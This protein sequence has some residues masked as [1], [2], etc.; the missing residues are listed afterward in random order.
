MDGRLGG[1]Q[2]TE[3]KAGYSIEKPRKKH[4]VGPF[5]RRRFV[6]LAS[7]GSL[8]ETVQAWSKPLVFH[9]GG[10][11]FVSGKIMRAIFG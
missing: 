4:D 1:V 5:W 8:E 9:A 10:L 11:S 3:Y 2:G 6:S 7:L